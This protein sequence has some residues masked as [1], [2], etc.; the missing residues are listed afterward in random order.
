VPFKAWWVNQGFAFT[1]VVGAPLEQL[2]LEQ[3][4]ANYVQSRHPDRVGSKA[5]TGH[6]P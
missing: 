5:G 6:S 3:F 1:P 4:F 2:H